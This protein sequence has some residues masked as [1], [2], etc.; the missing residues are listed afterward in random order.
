M[1]EVNFQ[2]SNFQASKGAVNSRINFIG[3]V[4]QS[5]GWIVTVAFILR[6]VVALIFLD[7]QL[8]PGRDHFGFGWETGRIAR[9]VALGEG[10]SS[11]FH[12]PT[13][14]TALMTPVY[15]YLVAAVFK[16]FG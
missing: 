12:G 13:G 5:P 7:A 10:F 11:P 3:R 14:P 4:Y 8:A 1:D 2:A 15:I 9:S 16:M 6:L